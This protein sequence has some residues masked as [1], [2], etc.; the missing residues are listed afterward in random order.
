MDGTTYRSYVV[1]VWRHGPAGGNVVRVLVEEVQSGR[2]ADLRG[3]CA[4]D[5]AVHLET[6]LYVPEG[7]RAGPIAAGTAEAAGAG[8]KESEP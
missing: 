4:A 1:R 6:A 3:A 5:L 2:Q 7:R 8:E